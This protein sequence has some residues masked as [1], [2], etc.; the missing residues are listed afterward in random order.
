M[1][2]AKSGDTGGGQAIGQAFD[3]RRFGADN[4][5]GDIFGRAK[6]DNRAM[7]LQVQICVASQLAGAAIAGRAKQVCGLRALGDFP[8]QRMLT[9]ATAKNQ[10]VEFVFCHQNAIMFV[11]LERNRYE[12]LVSYFL[13]H[14][15]S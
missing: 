9:P 8:T 12:N 15:L 1:A 7:I 2:G 3:Q 11:N 4:H 10:N 6:F 13:T 14:F 5:K